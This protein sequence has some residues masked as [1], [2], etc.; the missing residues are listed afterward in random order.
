MDNDDKYKSLEDLERRL[1]KSSDDDSIWNL[2][3]SVHSSRRTRAFIPLEAVAM[4]PFFADNATGK[5]ILS[6]FCVECKNAGNN[7]FFSP[8]GCVAWSYPDFEF[9]KYAV[10]KDVYRESSFSIGKEAIATK[11]TC[12]ELENFLKGNGNAPLAPNPLGD[13]YTEIFEKYLKTP[14]HEE[15]KP[16]N[17]PSAGAEQSTDGLLKLM[18]DTKQ[19]ITELKTDFLSNVWKN[20]YKKMQDSGFTVAVVGEFSRGKSTLINKILGNDI[21]PVS[22]LPTTAMLTKISHASHSEM[23]HILP[24]GKSQSYPLEISSWEE[25]IVNL[26]GDNPEGVVR[27]GLQNEWLK[28]TGLQIIDTPGAGDLSDKRSALVNDAIVGCDGAVIVV[29]A[30]MA[31][32]LTEKAFIEQHI[33]AKKV[34]HIMVVLSKMDQVPAK[35]R[36]SVVD[37]VR[38]RLD[39]WN[40]NVPVYIPQ[41]NLFSSDAKYDGMSGIQA[42]KAAIE[43]WIVDSQHIEL[44]NKRLL[45]P[46]ARFA[47]YRKGILTEE[48]QL[49]T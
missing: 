31:L 40:I 20:I 32:S 5:Y 15:T 9:A 37:Y 30:S 29:S 12:D 39:S 43:S 46:A 18:N 19:L 8:C 22:N 25:L 41:E 33:I 28:K 42:I 44:K 45:R 7:V 48:N 10:L 13:I 6:L 21:L 47:V 4:Q 3:N 17:I 2:V 24:D 1:N 34:P 26:L 11:T 23:E 36:G 35:E 16:Q 38:D 14:V 27:V 49:C